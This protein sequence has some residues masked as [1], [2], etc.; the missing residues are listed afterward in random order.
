MSRKTNLVRC[1][2]VAAYTS[3]TTSGGATHYNILRVPFTSQGGDSGAGAIY[4]TS[5]LVTFASLLIGNQGSNSYIMQA[6]RIKQGLRGADF[7]CFSSGNKGTTCPD[8][9]S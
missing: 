5:S 3:A 8:V 6:Y 1:N 9:D 7:N 4:P 2:Y